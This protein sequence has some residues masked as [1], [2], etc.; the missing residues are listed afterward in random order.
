MSSKKVVAQ[1]RRIKRRR[2]KADEERGTRRTIGPGADASRLASLQ[3]RV[4]NRAIQRLLASPTAQGT[5]ELDRET[6]SRAMTEPGEGV[7]A[8]SGPDWAGAFPISAS[9]NDLHV[10]FGAQVRRFVEALEEAG[11]AVEVLTTR[12]SPEAAYLMHWAWR[13]AKEDY[14][15]RRVPAME[16]VDIAWWHGDVHASKEAA[17]GMVEAYGIDALEAAPSLNSPHIQGNAIDMNISWEGDIPIRGSGGIEHLIA[18]EAAD[19]I[20]QELLAVAK[21]YGL[22]PAAD[23]TGNWLHW[24]TDGR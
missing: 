20:N 14:D 21:T 19:G 18:S 17:Q 7:Q 5:S 1:R 22:V 24:S 9:L 4:G 6:I 13:I 23:F 8:P 16:G 2:R 15:P 11:A 10:T 3:Q 12:W